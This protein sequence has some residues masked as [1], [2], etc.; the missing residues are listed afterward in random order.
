MKPLSTENKT[1]TTID[2][3][4]KKTDTADDMAK[5]PLAL[6]MM[7][8]Y[9]IQSNSMAILNAMYRE[10]V[11]ARLYYSNAEITNWEIEYGLFFIIKYVYLMCLI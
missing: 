1:E 8:N 4:A 11:P 3:N 2:T 9:D 5:Y 6:K 10:T 7:F